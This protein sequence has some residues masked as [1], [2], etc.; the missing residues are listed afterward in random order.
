MCISNVGSSV[1]GCAFGAKIDWGGCVTLDFPLYQY[2]ADVGSRE[3][4]ALKLAIDTH[5]ADVNKCSD[6][7]SDRQVAAPNE[8][9]VPR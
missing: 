1:G 6:S 7:F 4:R 5:C 9:P 8:R 2:E 3:G